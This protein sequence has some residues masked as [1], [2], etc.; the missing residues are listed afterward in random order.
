MTTTVATASKEIKEELILATLVCLQIREPMTAPL[1]ISHSPTSVC[2]TNWEHELWH[3]HH[4]LFQVFLPMLCFWWLLTA[5]IIS[6]PLFKACRRANRI[7][8]DR[9]RCASAELNLCWK[10]C[11]GTKSQ[12]REGRKRTLEKGPESDFSEPL[13][14][15]LSSLKRTER[16]SRESILTNKRKR[17]TKPRHHSRSC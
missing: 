11:S 1:R 5:Q 6:K 2:H 4:S 9:S 13:L 10:E 15:S 16:K 14:T 12:R 3:L 8:D 7:F 17:S